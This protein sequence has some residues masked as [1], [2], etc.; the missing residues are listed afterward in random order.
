MAFAN[1][2]AGT[3]KLIYTWKKSLVSQLPKISDAL[4][5]SYGQGDWDGESNTN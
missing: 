1:E 5:T 2:I 3:N 4:Q